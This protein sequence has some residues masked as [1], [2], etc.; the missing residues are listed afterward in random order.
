VAGLRDIT[1]D[2]TTPRSVHEA[3]IAIQGF[4]DELE[5]GGFAN[6]S[7]GDS[8][9]SIAGA[10]ERLERTVTNLAAAI[11][12]LPSAAPTE[13]DGLPELLKNPVEGFTEALTAGDLPRAERYLSRYEQVMGAS[14]S[15]LEMA[16]VLAPSASP[17]AIATIERCL[18][19]E[20]RRFEIGLVARACGALLSHYSL[21]DRES[22]AVPVVQDI[23]TRALEE[24]SDMA[25]AEKA[26]LLNQLGRAYSRA[27]DIARAIEL[28]E[29]AA[30]L[31][32]DEPVY[33]YNL[34]LNYEQLNLAQKA[35]EAVCRYTQLATGLDDDD[36]LYRA[37]DLFAKAGDGEQTRSLFAVTSERYP[38]KAKMLLAKPH[39][40]ELLQ[41][42]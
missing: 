17:V 18:R 41:R 21:L 24:I 19:S 42:A 20:L 26:L 36:R 11:T 14:Q 34:S 9:A 35:F 10:I 27:G 23:V 38:A 5:K 15:V 29:E 30:T 37:V 7:A 4:V 40:R 16:V 12:K 8:L 2:L 25:D 1:Y 22:D 6:V 28:Q 13:E 3:R 33:L 31:D 32:P 39:V